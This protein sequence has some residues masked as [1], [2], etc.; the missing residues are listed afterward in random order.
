MFSAMTISRRAWLQSGLA[1]GAL[2]VAKRQVFGQPAPTS[3]TPPSTPVPTV[4]IPKPPAGEHYTPVI[5]PD[6]H[7]LPFEKRGGVKIFHLI[8]GPIEHRFAPGLDVGA[9]GYNGSSPGP[10]IEAVTGDRVRIYVTNNLPE[11]TTV[12]WHGMVVPNGM[13]GVA[14]VTQP[15]IPPG[16]T[17]KYEFTL[18][19]AG[20]FNVC[21]PHYD[22]M[23]Q[24][25]LGMAGMFVVHPHESTGARDYALMLHEWRVPI[26]AARPDP[27]AMT[28]FNVLTFNGK[29]FPATTPLVAA[30]HD[31]VRVRIGNIG[32]MD[33][34]P[35][36]LHG[37]SF[38]VTET[39]GG[40]VPPSA[41][42]PETTVLVPAGAVRVFELVADALGDWPMHCH[43]THHVMNQMGHEA[44]NLIGADTTGVDSKLGR[45][46]PGSMTMG[47]NGTGEMMAMDRPRNSISMMGGPGPFGTIDMG[48]MFTILKVR[49][50]LTDASA[51]GWYEH[52][53]GTIA[54]EASADELVRDGV[55]VWPPMPLR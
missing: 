31:R 20:T 49:D 45:V 24:I 3:I 21:H 28:D 46:V 12:H 17:F 35:I 15:R 55:K 42:A 53:A 34:H 7:T 30:R 16:K 36:H 10:V 41:R 48:G 44:A 47:T 25:A 23:T 5:V 11:P 32:P 43:M 1:A 40:T 6:G 9:W 14:G 27:L 37:Y 50:P 4:A 29:A 51:A 22:E 54:G 26:G 18:G 19:R 8:A 33:H 13:D 38:E 39:D 2:V 52:P